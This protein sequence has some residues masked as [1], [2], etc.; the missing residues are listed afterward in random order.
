M[1][2]ELRAL[3]PDELPAICAL[4]NRSEAHDGVPR[5]LE[6]E[7]LEE[8]LEAVSLADDLRVAEVDG[9]LAGYAYTLLLPSD[10]G[11]ERCY[12]LGEV[13]PVHRGKGA[14]RALLAWGV[15]RGSEQLRG[16]G[17]DLPKYL[18]VDSY[19]Y[20][21]SAHRLYARLGFTPVRWF[22]ELIR[23][24]SDLPPLREVPGVSLL[25]WPEGAEAEEESLLVKNESFA[26]HWGSTPTTESDWHKQLHGFGSRL[27]LSAVAVED[28]TS[29]VVGLCVNHRYEADDELLGRK[30]GWIMT[31]GTLK[32]WRGRGIASAL[33]VRSLHAFAEAGLTHASIGVDSES[34][35]GA[36]L[37]YRR[38]GFEPVQRSVTH[39][40]T[41]T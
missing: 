17:R 5:V 9:A 22:E 24:L 21:E 7:E 20:I 12:V 1:S 16:T 25:G 19:D 35:S 14:G 37:L 28:A 34:P 6:L 13:D 39:Q 11:W 26:D 10:T 31:L 3:R 36:N 27:D 30:D 23:P 8:E 4:H 38:L 32:A 18:R 40:I 41:V 15:E 33:V 2:V 29:R